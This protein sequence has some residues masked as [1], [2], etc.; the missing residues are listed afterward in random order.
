MRFALLAG[1]LALPT[2]LLAQF[3]DVGSYKGHV[4]PVG[5]T[6]QF[7]LILK[8]ERVADSTTIQILQGADQPPIPIAS[9]HVISGGF[10]IAFFN[11]ACPLVVVEQQWEGICEDQFGNPSVTLRFSRTAEPPAAP[12]TTSPPRQGG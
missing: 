8:V 5:S 6:G 3:P 9:R 11:L 10:G 4:Q 12:S 7:E 2:T 1:T